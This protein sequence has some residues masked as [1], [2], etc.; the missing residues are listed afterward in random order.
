MTMLL[1]FWSA[2]CCTFLYS[3]LFANPITTVDGDSLARFATINF[4]YDQLLWLVMYVVDD[5]CRC[6]AGDGY[7]CN[8]LGLYTLSLISPCVL[9][10]NITASPAVQAD[11][12]AWSYVHCQ[13]RGC[14]KL[15]FDIF[16]RF[17][18]MWYLFIV[19]AVALF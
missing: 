1:S 3:W 19:D 10:L 15:L 17:V 8:G 7:S 11:V 13:R 6:G 9:Y 5:C 16:V 4:A 12:W 18:G 14:L 2:V